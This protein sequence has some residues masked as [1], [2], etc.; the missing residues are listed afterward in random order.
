MAISVEKDLTIVA[1]GKATI[2]STDNMTLSTKGDL[3]IECRNFN[4]KATANA[5]VESNGQRGCER[6]PVRST[7][8]ERR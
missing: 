8:R 2:E 1:K 7:S 6:G 3:N 5:K 4:V